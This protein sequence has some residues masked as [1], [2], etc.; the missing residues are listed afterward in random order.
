MEL[1]A[2]PQVANPAALVNHLQPLLAVQMVNPA[3]L[4]NLLQLQLPAVK[5]LKQHPLRKT[6][7]T[8]IYQIYKKPALKPAF[9]FSPGR[10]SVE[11]MIFL[12]KSPFYP[13][14]LFNHQADDHNDNT[15]ANHLNALYLNIE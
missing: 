9:L 3:A 15:G 10:C 5:Q 1:K 11:L 14:G 2:P 12:L 4:A 8:G 13:H 7:R 6:N